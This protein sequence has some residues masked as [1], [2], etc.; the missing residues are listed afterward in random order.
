MKKVKLLLMA[1][2][3]ICFIALYSCK[4]GKKEDK[5][6]ET[7]EEVQIEQDT[8]MKEEEEE[9]KMEEEEETEE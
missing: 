6:K 9:E 3:V 2:A 4:D 8:T 1:L 5:A 7:T